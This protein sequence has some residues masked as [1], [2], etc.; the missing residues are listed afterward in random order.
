VIRRAAILLGVPLGCAV[1]AAIPLGM[2]RGNYQWLCAT[3]AVVLVVPPGLITLILADRLAR[4]SLFGPLLALAIGTAVRVLV[5]FG[6]AVAVFLAAKPTF[7]NDPF[8]FLA[9]LLGVYLTTLIVETVLLAGPIGA[10]A[11]VS[12]GPAKG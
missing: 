7:A 5:A 2:W 12:A 9:W 10:A 8:S 4:A 3:V 1:L 6:G 11:K